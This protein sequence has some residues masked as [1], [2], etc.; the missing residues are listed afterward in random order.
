ME[1]YKNIVLLEDEL[2]DYISDGYIYIFFKIYFLENEIKL[3]SVICFYGKINILKIV[4]I[5]DFLLW[6]M[7]D[8]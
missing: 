6:I 8:K 2:F 3:M 4:I 7:I 5:I 1:L